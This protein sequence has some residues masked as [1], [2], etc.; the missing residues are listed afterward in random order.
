MTLYSLPIL[1]LRSAPQGVVE[2]FA[3]VFGGIDSYGD[4]VLPGAFA[5]SLTAHSAKNTSPAML[6]SHQTD[7]PVG[8]WEQLAETSRG[9]HV[10]GRLNLKTQAGRDAFEHLRAGDIT[11]LSIGY[12]VAPGGSERRGDVTA[13]KALDLHE[14]SLVTLP[15]DGNARVTA[16]K[17][18]A[19]KPATVRQFEE[20]LRDLGFSRREAAR[21]AVK[22]FGDFQP[23]DDE[24]EIIQAIKAATSLFLKA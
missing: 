11:G 3:S 5:A 17:S 15:A 20:S 23:E 18:A 16:V 4:S 12:R 6:W 8:R 19:E 1:E 7:A 21:I 14:I 10:Q 13:L 22:G 2:G 9:L 24:S